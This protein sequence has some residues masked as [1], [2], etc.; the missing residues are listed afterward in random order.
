VVARTRVA[1]VTGGTRGIGRAVTERL[2]DS[3]VDVA[4][5]YATDCVAAESVQNRCEK[6]GA[7]VTLHRVDVGDPDSCRR[8]VDEVSSTSPSYSCSDC[9]RATGRTLSPGSCSPNGGCSPTCQVPSCKLRP[10][11]RARCRARRATGS[12]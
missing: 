12:C 11:V 10:A 3:G 5:A 9:Y 4:A 1:L 2:A 7:R 8:L 6:T